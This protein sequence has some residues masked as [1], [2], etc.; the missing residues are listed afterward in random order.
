M[1]R[2]DA[3]LRRA[4]I[5]GVASSVGLSASGRLNS[6]RQTKADRTSFGEGGLSL[7]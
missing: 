4:E 2:I 5:P 6:I 7:R 3:P 1:H